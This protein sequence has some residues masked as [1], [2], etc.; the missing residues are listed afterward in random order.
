MTKVK[1]NYILNLIYQI[2]SLITPLLVTPYISRVLGTVGIGQYSFCYA[3]AS[4]FVL[5][6]AI[7]FNTYSQ[8]E[9][10]RVQDDKETQTKL[11]WEIFIA[12]FLSVGVSLGIFLIVIFAGIDDPIYK[13]LLLIM[14]INVV[15]TIFDIAYFFQGREQF[16][17]IVLWNIIVKILGIAGI[18]IFVKTE[19]DIYLYA[20]FQ[21]LVL[22]GSNIVLWTRLPKLLSKVRFKELNIK[23]HYVPALRLFIPTVAI[24]VYTMLDKTLIGLLIPGVTENGEKVADLE[25]GFY[26][27]AEKIVKMTMTIIT[28]LGTVMIPRNSNAIAT[29]NIEEFKSNVS[30]ALKFVAFLGIP[31]MFGLA[32]IAFNFSPWFF[33]PGYEKVPSLMMIFSTLV[34]FIGLSNVLGIQYLL[35]LKRDRDYTTA[36]ICGSVINL[37]LNL[38][39][40]PFFWSYGACIASIVA[41]LTVTCVMFWFARKD[42]SFLKFLGS[43]W[44][45]ILSGAVMFAVVFL[46][47]H[48]LE[49][50][51]LHT[52]LLIAEGAATYLILLL[53]FRDNILLGFIR[54][55]TKKESKTEE[56]TN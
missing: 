36:I 29:G 21:S 22:I 26:D 45:Y 6:A 8:R 46:T 28:S 5:L 3:L 51:L 56:I 55:I 7:G 25:N 30:G 17:T 47:Q 19:Q 48:F 24:S 20:L 4:Y 35:P 41:E 2:F 1:K 10:S 40:I 23:R 27:Q 53:C 44:K 39:L 13:K 32:A 16:G 31:L 54:K 43:S 9:I 38:S 50:S 18:F 34:L 33:G 49:P 12:R 37:I 15:A 11:F 42:V 14:V 52:L